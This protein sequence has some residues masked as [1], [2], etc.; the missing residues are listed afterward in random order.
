VTVTFVELIVQARESLVRAGISPARAALDAD[1]L[2]RHASGWDRATWLT[3][4]SEAADA[5]FEHA[6]AALVA[7]RCTREP[8]AYIRGVQEFWGRDFLVTPDVL[9]PRPETEL[10]VETALTFVRD[11]PDL[12]LVDVGTGTG[13]IAITL[14]LE[15]PSAT[16]W[17]TDTSAAAL[18]VARENARRLGAVDRVTFVHGRFLAGVA[19]PLELIVSNPPYVRERDRSGLAPEV[20]NYEPG[21][22][23]FAGEDGLRDVRALLREAL[24]ILPPHGRLVMEF[25]FG[26]DAVIEQ[27]IRGMTGLELEAILP[28]LQGI[29]RVVVVAPAARSAAK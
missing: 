5:I 24:E 17:A 27:E 16:I 7:R 21:M 14:T 29:P 3:R 2:G 9:I 4:R 26:Q 28:D 6:F 20:V 18:Q 19:R 1:L 11:Q 10:V 25:G 13:C 15:C 12:T 22:A 23:L 8:V